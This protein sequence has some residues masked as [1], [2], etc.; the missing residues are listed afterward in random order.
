MLG[1]PQTVLAI[2]LLLGLVACSPGG[3][4]SGGPV[5]ANVAGYWV[6]SAGT[7]FYVLEQSGSEVTGKFYVTEGGTA[8]TFADHVYECGLLGGKVSGR[9]LT[10]ETIMTPQNCPISIDS[11]R[12]L[13]FAITGQVGDDSFSGTVNWTSFIVVG[14]TRQVEGTGSYSTSWENVPSTDPR[15]QYRL[16]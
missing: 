3:A 9:T 2:A 5:T 1:K 6:V 12:E 7:S 11:G 15:V 4:P 10:I 16:D 8:L 14:G 13:R